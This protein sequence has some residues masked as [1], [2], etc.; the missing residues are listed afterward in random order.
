LNP[1]SQYL[2]GRRMYTWILSH[3][4][5]HERSCVLINS[6]NFKEK[7]VQVTGRCKWETYFILFCRT[8][9]S[10]MSTRTLYYNLLKRNTTFFWW[11][12]RL[13]SEIKENTNVL[14]HGEETTAVYQC[15]KHV[16]RCIIM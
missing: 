1:P 14:H 15:L 8:C 4:D 11:Q 16:L 9:F 13:H 5:R 10:Y 7:K 3:Y 2:K 12:K 6:F